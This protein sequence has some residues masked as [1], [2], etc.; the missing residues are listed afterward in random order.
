M[1]HSLERM[2]MSSLGK[3]DWTALGGS[4]DEEVSELAG[5]TGC[6]SQTKREVSSQARLRQCGVSNS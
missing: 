1:L 6:P 4:V 5:M 3:F 2:L